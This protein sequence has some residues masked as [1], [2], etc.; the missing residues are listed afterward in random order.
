MAFDPN[1]LIL[2]PGD[3]YTAAFG[4]VEPADTA[5]ATPPDDLVWTDVGGTE[6]GVNFEQNLEFTQLEVDQ[7]ID[8][9]ESRCTKREF[10]L[11]VNLAEVTL[12][13]IKL[14]NNGG[15]ITTGGTGA[16]AHSKYT[17]D[18]DVTSGT[19]PNYAAMLF[20]GP[21]PSGVRRRFVGR[22]MLQ[23]GEVKTS[24][25]KED[26]AVLECE[27]LGHAVSKTVAPYYYIDETAA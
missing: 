4:A 15:T 25:H 17:P 5:F 12:E 14:A 8:A 22:K 9:P 24:Y 18:I 11:V 13:N 21:A 2:G 3:L 27:F 6:D 10:K 1:N 23:V 26:Q 7:A 20:D 16:T 19:R